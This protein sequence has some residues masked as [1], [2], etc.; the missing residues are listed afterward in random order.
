[1][2][3]RVWSRRQAMGGRRG[4]RLPRVARMVKRRRRQG[5]SIRVVRDWER[6]S[7]RWSRQVRV[8]WRSISLMHWRCIAAWRRRRSLRW[9]SWRWSVLIHRRSHV[10]NYSTP[11]HC[12]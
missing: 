3:I 11:F 5:Q 7:S 10:S 12:S 2:R 6:D 1:M 9:P 4:K 8:V